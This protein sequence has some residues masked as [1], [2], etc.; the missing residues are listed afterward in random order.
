MIS[1]IH[2]LHRLRI[3]LAACALTVLAGC[4]STPSVRVPSGLDLPEKD[5]SG[6]GQTLDAGIEGR[7]TL[8]QTSTPKVE[9][10]WPS[11]SGAQTDD[12]LPPM[13]AAGRRT[14]RR[15]QFY[16]RRRHAGRHEV[17]ESAGRALAGHAAFCID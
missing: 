3:V 11:L 1:P 6:D 8:T 2:P 12:A 14:D 13:S 17:G 7:Q 4:V 16:Q 10:T 15:I 9:G 5:Q